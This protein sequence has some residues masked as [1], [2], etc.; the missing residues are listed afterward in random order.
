MSD[1]LEH[2]QATSRLAIDVEQVPGEWFP[3]ILNRV[4]AFLDQP[5][6][7]VSTWC[8]LRA[9]SRGKPEVL[10]KSLN[11]EARTSFAAAL[12]WEPEV[13]IGS[14]MDSF[15]EVVYNH[16]AEGKPSQSK[17]WTRGSG[18]RYC[19]ECLREKPGVFYAH[20]RLSWSFVCLTHSLVLRDTCSA[21]GQTP[22]ES[23][24]QDRMV[25]DPSRCRNRIEGSG[26]LCGKPFE[27]NWA[28]EPLS[29]DSRLL[30]AQRAI[31]KRWRPVEDNYLRGVF[32]ASREPTEYFFTLRGA[33]IAL[34]AA[35][36]DGLLSDLAGVPE[37]TFAAFSEK[38]PR[39]GATAPKDAYL[40]GGL[41][42]AAHHLQAA[43][44]EEVR[45]AIRRVTFSRPVTA[46]EDAL[47]PGSAAHLL[48]H[49]PSIGSAM[50][51][52][53]LRAIDDDLP[54]IQRLIWGS[55]GRAEIDEL[56]NFASSFRFDAKTP[57]G[58]SIN[59]SAHALLLGAE[60]MEALVP[61]LMWT[62]W[63]NPLGVNP[64]TDPSALQRSLTQALQIAGLAAWRRSGLTEADVDRIAGI[65]KK[66]R[67][68]MLGNER[69][70]RLV[71]Q[72][73]TELAS[74][75]RSSPAPINYR[76][77]RF[78]A[79][80]SLL[81]AGHWRLI[82]ESVGES[83]GSEAKLLRARRYMY[84]RA[85]GTGT[86]DLPPQWQI[87]ASTH[88]AADYTQFL[89]TM[90]AEL[91]R[92]IDQYLAAWLT[93]RGDSEDRRGL[94]SLHHKTPAPVIW[95]PP[96][97][98]DSSAG[99]GPELE[100]IDLDTLH[101]H[102][103]AGQYSMTQMARAV[104]RT[105]RHVRW[106]L[107][108]NPVRSGNATTQIDWLEHIPRTKLFLSDNIAAVEAWASGAQ[109]FRAEEG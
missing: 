39:T 88:D 105:P 5:P 52:R 35:D 31:T 22:Y 48:S 63:A 9:H 28:E 77:R 82:T 109:E 71:L 51:G 15:R 81:P 65:G 73:L 10:G 33:G 23:R 34:M 86:R 92:A 41:M 54:P 20:W 25:S 7:A 99:L 61:P 94:P 95:N 68:D 96:R 44:E 46:S 97:W 75:L 29:A 85:T 59:N 70:Q 67:P 26:E 66:L 78:L 108:A 107:A 36:D 4:A 74:L 80:W 17:M 101:A 106:A 47:G 53:V 40:M 32:Y 37:A 98:S 89:T 103:R 27:D 87:R 3:S 62:N 69:Q 49:W 1:Q 84:L 2:A 57:Q 19:P 38:G 64:R 79:W 13:L 6:A 11:D 104:D 76:R 90:S 56:A 30:V 60:P 102:V 24:I 43:P 14:A 50:E 42:A 72:Q 12:G 18:T 16:R 93:K 58:R 8:H 21:C 55:A 83:P 45:E 100:D 91:A